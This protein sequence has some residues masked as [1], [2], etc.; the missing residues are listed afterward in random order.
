M[1]HYTSHTAGKKT[2]RSYKGVPIKNDDG[3]VEHL[4]LF[5]EDVTE[6][7]KLH[8]QL[9]GLINNLPEGILIEDEDRKITYVNQDFCKLFGINIPACDLIGNDCNQA[10]QQSKNLFINPDE[11][12]NRVDD[13][14]REKKI[15]QN[16]KLLLVDGRVFERDYIPVFS[17]FEYLGNMWA[18][19]DI[20]EQQKI[21][22]VKNDIISLASHQLKTPLTAIKLLTE[23]LLGGKMGI[24]TEKQKE[25]LDDIQS[26]NQRMIGLVNALL[27]VSRIEMGVF[28]IQVRENDPCIIVENIVDELKP[29]IDKKKLKL[30]MISLEKNI[31]LEVDEPLF[32]MVFSNL[33]VN[34]IHYTA[35]GGEIR[36]ECKVVNKGQALGGKLLEEDCFVIVVSDTG[37]GIS[38]KQQ[39]KVFTKFFRADNAREKYTNGSGL[40]L[41]IA[42]SIL[43]NS[44]GSIWF[45]SRENEGSE[46]YTAIPLTGMKVKAGKKELIA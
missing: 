19:R 10:S 6:K 23:R 37:C 13:L 28:S 3:A 34:A 2:V 22:Q 43:D 30:K 1:V 39:S 11:F 8:R 29:V 17:E 46:F 18:Y 27:N 32:R 4:L 36:I 31:I 25:Y 24:F 41:Y 33:V 5:V 9:N 35:E 20:T 15:Q 14:L 16:D 45:T 7:D 40:G 38:R 21:E 42:K 44:G 12:I 26:S